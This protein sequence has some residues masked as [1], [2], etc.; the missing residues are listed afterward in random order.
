MCVCVREC[1]C[2]CELGCEFLGAGVLYCGR[3]N[4]GEG[5]PGEGTGGVK[6]EMERRTMCVYICGIWLASSLCVCVSNHD[7]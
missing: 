4:V 6:G 2:V 1:V 7:S 3:M 5:G